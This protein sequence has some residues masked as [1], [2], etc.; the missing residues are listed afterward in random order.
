MTALEHF[1]NKEVPE[2][3]NLP[4]EWRKLENAGVVRIGR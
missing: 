3:G 4:P 2:S 1:K